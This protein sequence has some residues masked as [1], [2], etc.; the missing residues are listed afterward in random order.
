MKSFS[1]LLREIV[2][3]NTEE[4]SEI[5]F[6]ATGF[7]V[8]MVSHLNESC[9]SLWWRQLVHVSFYVSVS[10]SCEGDLFWNA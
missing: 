9:M 10:G 8:P 6:C 3:E 4:D 7:K 1:W 5:V 2:A